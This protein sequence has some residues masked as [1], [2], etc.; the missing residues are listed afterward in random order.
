MH[1]HNKSNNFTARQIRCDRQG[2]TPSAHTFLVLM[3]LLMQCAWY[4]WS[5]YGHIDNDREVST[6]ITQS[7]EIDGTPARTAHAPHNNATFEGRILVQ[8]AVDACRGGSN[9][10]G[11]EF[12]A[13]CL[14]GRDCG[15]TRVSKQQC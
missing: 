4:A 14:S 11:K 5:A 7:R 9:D 13:G 3:N 2:H 8:H 6:R 15:T 12:N 10:G 1:P